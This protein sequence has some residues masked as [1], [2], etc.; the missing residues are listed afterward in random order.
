M[1]GSIRGFRLRH[2]LRFPFKGGR[3]GDDPAV[4]NLDSLGGFAFFPKVVKMA[5]GNAVFLAE[6]IDRNG[7]EGCLIFVYAHMCL[8]KLP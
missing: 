6:L 7:S 1:A 4:A 8:L 2:H 5:I 3:I